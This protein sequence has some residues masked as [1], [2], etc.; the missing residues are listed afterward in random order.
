MCCLLDRLP[1]FIELKQEI[2]EV[3]NKAESCS[4]QLKA[5]AE[6]IQNSDHKGE[7]YVTEKLKRSDQAAREREEFLRS[8][9][10]SERRMPL[11]ATNGSRN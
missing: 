3:K 10:K 9:W 4:K 11:R 8:C 6:S 7:R 1:G 5:W 2:R